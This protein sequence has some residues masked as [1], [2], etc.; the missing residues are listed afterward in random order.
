M[1]KENPG[2]ERRVAIFYA[3]PAIVIALPTIPVYLNLP[4]LYGIDLGIGLAAT[5]GILLLARLFDTLTDPLIGVLSDRLSMKGGRRRPWIAIGAIFAGIGLFKIL[6][7]PEVVS[8]TYL[9]SWSLVLYAG[10]TMVNVPYLA[11]GAELS[12]DYDKRTRITAWREG[13]TLVGILAAGAVT[14]VTAQFGWKGI[15]SIGAISWVAIGC[16]MIVLPLMLFNVPDYS[17]AMRSKQR[18]S[19]FSNLFTNLPFLRLLGSWFI[20]G[21]ANGIPAALFLIYLEYGLGADKEVL[22]LFVLVYFS[23]GIASIPVWLWLSSK[24]GKH[25]TWCWAM[26]TACAAFVGVPFLPPGAFVAFGIICVITG[27]A[28]GADLTLPPS[29]QADVI[30][31]DQWRFG[32]DRV[33]LQFALWGMSTKFALALGVGFAL[34]A[35]EFSGFTPHQPSETSLWAL[36]VIY[37]LIPAVLKLIAVSIIWQFPLTRARHLAIR[38][39]LDRR[40]RETR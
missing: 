6:N 18:P 7:P 5:G 32:S 19:S 34:P 25:Q 39:R 16:G 36:V 20:N 26:I 21:L 37:A 35:L 3:L 40:E 29:I 14:G 9:L 11:W 27:M 4:A 31:Y 22:P 17:I 1:N 13:M 15:D 28:L 33:G 10:W 30:D 24:L 12:N 23:S 2:S 38:R 8:G